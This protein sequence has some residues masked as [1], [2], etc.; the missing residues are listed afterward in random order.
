L[1]VG[2]KRIKVIQKLSP[3]IIINQQRTVKGTEER[4]EQ[5]DI[6]GKGTPAH[7]VKRYLRNAERS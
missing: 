3:N 7:V 4:K 1:E 2:I 5:V 6:G